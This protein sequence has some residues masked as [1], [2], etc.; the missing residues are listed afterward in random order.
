MAQPAISHR[1]A[2]AACVKHFYCAGGRRT[3]TCAALGEGAQ[4]VQV[5]RQL[6]TSFVLARPRTL[7][8]YLHKVAVSLWARLLHCIGTPAFHAAPAF[9]ACLQ[10]RC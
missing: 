3:C 2:A 1:L 4:L 10:L 6:F 5:S 8:I 7:Q 9:L